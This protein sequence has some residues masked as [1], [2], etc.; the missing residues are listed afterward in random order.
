MPAVQIFLSTVTSEFRSYRDALRHD[1]DRPNV[2]VKV[3]E[4]FVATG[5]ETL[6]LLDEYIK[7]CDAVIHLVGDMTG[8]MAQPPSVTAIRERYPDFDKR[9]PVVTSFLRPGGPA[10]PYTQWEAWLALYHGKPLF[11]CV[12]QEGAPRDERYSLDQGQR[13]SQRDHLERLAS[14]ERYPATRFANADRLAVDVLRSKLQD[15]LA[16]AADPSAGGRLIDFTQERMRHGEILGREQAIAT[17]RGWIDG[18]SSGWGLIKGGPGTGKSAILVAILNQHENEYGPDSA[19]YHFLRRDQG[20]WN[21]PDAVVNNLTARLERMSKFTRRSTA[22]GLERLNAL[23]VAMA[24]QYATNNRRLLLI[25]DGL[26]EAPSGVEHVLGRF[27]PAALPDNVFILC[28]SRPNYPELG[29]LDQRPGLH[30]ID[31]DKPPW[32]GDNRVVVEAYWRK[33]GPQLKP[34]LDAEV[35]EK[36]IHAAEGNMLHAVTLFDAF[37]TNTQ[38]RDPDRIPVGFNALLEDLWVRLVALKD[39]E[40]SGRVLAGLGLLAVAGEALPL[41]T[42]ARLLGWKHPGDIADFKRYA[43]PFLLV[44]SADWH[45][46]EAH[47]RPFHES[48]REF[49]TSGDHMLPDVFR[50]Y[51]ELLARRLA[52]WPPLD[53]AREW[54][55]GY[56]AQFALVHLSAA[57][58][59]R[60]LTE[61][62]GDLSYF[63][64][65]LEALGPQLL[66]ARIEATLAAG[67]SAQTVER[68]RVLQRVLRLESQL[69]ALSPRELPN[70]IHNRLICLGWSRDRIRSSFSGFDRGWGL[71]NA[72][73]MGDEIC[74]FRGHTSS[75]NTCAIDSHGRYGVSG[76]WD[77]NVRIWDLARGASLHVLRSHPEAG[78][79]DVDSCDI[80]PDG[81]YI[82]VSLSLIQLEPRREYGRIQVWE[83]RDGQLKHDVDHSSS[84]SARVTFASNEKALACHR[85]GYIDIYDIPRGACE[86]LMLNEEITGGIAVNG[87]GNLFAGITKQGCVVWRLSDGNKLSVVPLENAQV[88]SFSPN[89]KSIAVGTNRRALIANPVDGSVLHSTENIGELSDCRLLDSNRLLITS[90]WDC[91]VVVWNVE[92]DRAVVSFEGHTYTAACCSATP[93]GQLALTGGGD[94][95]VRLWSLVEKAGSPRIDRHAKLVYGC[96]INAEAT[97]ACSAPQEESPVIWNARTGTRVLP[98]ETSVEY[99]SVRFCRFQDRSRLAAIGGLLRLFDP[100]TARLEWEAEIPVRD[101]YGRVSWVDDSATEGALD[102]FGRGQVDHLPLFFAGSHAIVWDATGAL[103]PV[104]IPGKETSVSRL[105]SGQAIAALHD[106]ILEIVNLNSSEVPIQIA[107]GVKACVGS[108]SSHTVFAAMLNGQLCRLDAVSGKTL[109]VLGEIK[110]EHVRLL[111]DRGE[112]TLWAICSNRGPRVALQ[113]PTDEVLM[114]FSPEASSLLQQSGISG[115]DVR[116]CCFLSSMLVTSGWS[117]ATLRVWDAHQPMPLTVISGSSPFRCVDAARDRLIAGDQKGNVW[118]LAPLGQLYQ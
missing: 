17:V 90:G 105:N 15:I 79:C 97:L 40:V 27:L 44:E 92:T 53:G 112:T 32:L 116:D 95:T 71:I 13:T 20:N 66:M 83:T 28:A 82:V 75:V 69:L 104:P 26:D 111:I 12:P 1:L 34:P 117:D 52:A 94:D 115:H 7:E 24:A 21:E 51:H 61:L 64:A 110:Q 35:L 72:V 107:K 47:Y 8:A 70:L 85:A 106:N 45:G 89:G 3:Q 46:G 63:V 42:V 11:I 80:S 41:S 50:E 14:I 48:T 43:L 86:R 99:G 68:A 81:R 33:R 5:T 49:L 2:T 30:T 67:Q 101:Q 93:D 73:A 29:W 59:W 18:A 9:L 108:P 88:C 91:Q 54:E 22:Q 10:L 37:A 6:D 118:F 56:A 19:P 62:F 74:I 109:A 31:L 25:V 60:R 4:D 58:D 102:S 65:A 113:S 76:G 36:A 96:T 100:E 84:G 87:P 16:F 114:A 57:V 39:R 103:R 55:R 23:L 78:R 38:A 77:G 98:V